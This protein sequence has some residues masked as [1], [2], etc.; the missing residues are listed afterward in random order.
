V[1]E[2]IQLLHQD[3]SDPGSNL[4]PNPCTSAHFNPHP[5]SNPKPHASSYASSH[6]NTNSYADAS[7]DI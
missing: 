7:I 4:S 2:T 3:S 5:G 6:T 1:Q